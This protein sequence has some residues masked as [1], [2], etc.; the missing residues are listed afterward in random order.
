[1]IALD[2]TLELTHCT[3]QDLHNVFLMIHK[4]L[5]S[6]SLSE[7]VKCDKLVEVLGL[8]KDWST[9]YYNSRNIIDTEYP[10]LVQ[11]I[12]VDTN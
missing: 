5:D 9:Y 4:K 6:I 11:E 7:L 10:D 1:M 8:D 2:S 12:N 3:L